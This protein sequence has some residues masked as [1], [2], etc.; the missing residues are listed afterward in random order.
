MNLAKRKQRRATRR[1]NLGITSGVTDI[2]LGICWVVWCEH[3]CDRAFGDKSAC[4]HSDLHTCR[5]V[6]VSQW[7]AIGLPLGSR[8]PGIG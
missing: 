3:V 2:S 5:G 6:S 7:L 1:S 4:V 8:P